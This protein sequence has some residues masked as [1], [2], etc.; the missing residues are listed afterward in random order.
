MDIYSR[1]LI[2]AIFDEK[3]GEL[4]TKPNQPVRILAPSVFASH[5]VIF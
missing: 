1:I 2:D 5:S 4:G 3:S